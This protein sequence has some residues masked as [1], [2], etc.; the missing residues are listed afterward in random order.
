MSGSGRQ[1]HWQLEFVRGIAV[2]LMI[3]YHFMWDM[4]FFELY[5]HDVTV[6]G[7][8]LFAR[9]AATLFV[10]LVGVSIM[11]AGERREPAA[12][13]RAWYRRGLQLLGFGLAITL[14]TRMFLGDAFILFGI[15]HLVGTTMLLAPLLWRAR[16]V[17]P[18]IGAALIWLGV[19]FD[20]IS[21]DT[22]WLLPL[23]LYPE[24]YP[25]VDFFPLVPWLGIVMIGMGFGQLLLLRLPGQ[26][27]PDARVPSVLIP[28]V[29]L[30]RHSLLIYLV[31]QPILL[32]GFW[33]LGYTVW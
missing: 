23:G 16:N 12:R 4:S 25:A 13:N 5:P 6:G 32:A 27:P 15:L 1:R 9:S 33:L 26:A 28:I 18:F 31:H 30:G 2:I 20:R 11:L 14:I 7:W 3:F 17:A 22:Y 21:V 29:A 10:L 24:H 19:A 8:W